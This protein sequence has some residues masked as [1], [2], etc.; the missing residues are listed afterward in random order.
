MLFERRL[1]TAS[2]GTDYDW[3]PVHQ[4]LLSLAQFL[5]TRHVELSDLPGIDDLVTQVFVTL[6]FAI[7]WADVILPDVDAIAR[8]YYE[9]LRSDNTI[10]K[11]GNLAAPPPS[12]TIPPPSPRLGPGSPSMRRHDSSGHNTPKSPGLQATPSTT[13]FGPPEPSGPAEQ[14]IRN[15]AVVRGH[16]GEKVEDFKE[17]SGSPIV[18]AHQVLAII[19]SSMDG[20]DLRESMALEDM[21]M[22]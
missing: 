2:V 8:L 10:S 4:A 21:G 1:L 6:D 17:K 20:M 18:E 5:V 13:S 22:K 3:H 7:I 11:L 14:S 9:L 19:K 16:L 15:L 12:L